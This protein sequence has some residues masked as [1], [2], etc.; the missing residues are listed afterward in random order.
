MKTDVVMIE[1]GSTMSVHI[2]VLRNLWVL[3]WTK[4][5]SHVFPILPHFSNLFPAVI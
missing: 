2:S 4:P 3:E 1:K 5:Q